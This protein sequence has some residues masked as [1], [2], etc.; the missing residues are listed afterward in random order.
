GEAKR[1][2]G[3]QP[4][5]LC[6]RRHRALV[7]RRNARGRG[8][9]VRAW[10]RGPRMRGPP[11]D[12]SG[13]AIAAAAHGH[14]VAIVAAPLAERV[15]Q[16]RDCLVEVVLL[17]DDMRPY[18]RHQRPLV[19][20]LTGVLDEHAQR[21][22]RARREGN[23]PAVCSRAQQARAGIEPVR[24]EF[25]YPAPFGLV[26]GRRL[27]SL[28]RFGC[29]LGVTSILAAGGPAGTGPRAGARATVC[30]AWA[31]AHLPPA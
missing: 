31:A 25:V 21:V 4:A 3:P 13:E 20:E 19:H 15:P 28:E 9:R 1:N 23:G 11:L 7:A 24:A 30:S 14:D 18:G 17:D 12:R 27:S 22:V 2:A 26:H 6:Y 16:R 29:P 5:G 8:A 10:S